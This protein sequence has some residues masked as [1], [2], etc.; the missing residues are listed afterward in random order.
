MTSAPRRQS[1]RCSHV[2][3]SECRRPRVKWFGLVSRWVKTRCFAQARRDGFTLIEL[4][5]IMLILVI[6]AAAVIP[7]IGDTTGMRMSATARK[8][9][10]DI[11]F[12]QSLAMTGGQRY[13]V[14]FNLAPAPAAGYAVV[15]NTDGDA[16]WGEA[17]EFARDPVGGG[18]LSVTLN[19]GDYAGVTISAVGFSGSFVEFDTLGRPYDNLGL[20]AAGNTVTMAGGSATQTVT[21]TQQT[22][23]VTVP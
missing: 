2:V 15:N 4:V 6:V 16:N 1:S 18:T 20:L 14:Y 5:I 19:T 9:Q 23:R 17:G 11:A 21:V 8:V 7:S 10:S 3:T 12:A 22:G 13:R